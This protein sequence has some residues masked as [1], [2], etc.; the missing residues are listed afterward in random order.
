MYIGENLSGWSFEGCEADVLAGTRLIDFIR[1]TADHG[2]GGMELMA[3]IPG[4][5]GGGL[6]MNAGAFGQEIASSVIDVSG[7]NFN[8]DRIQAARENIHFEY[9]RVSELQDVVITSARFRY[10]EHDAAGLKQRIGNILAVRGKK[11]P[12][13]QASCGSVFKRPVG[14]FAGALIEEAGLKG[15]RIGGAEVSLKHAGFILNTGDASA[16]DVYKL[17][18][19]VENRV[20]RRFG[21]HLEREVKLIGEF[22]T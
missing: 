22:D 5:V 18:R 7:F 15:E 13:N 4:G 19:R 8:G 10:S 12:L 14:Y 3:G 16:A 11:Q 20:F 1:A 6:R 2:L 17:I 9:R 21:I